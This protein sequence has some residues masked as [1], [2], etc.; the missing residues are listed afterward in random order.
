MSMED[1]THKQWQQT[2]GGTKYKEFYTN[3]KHK[4]AVAKLCLLHYLGNQFW[5]KNIGMAG[6]YLNHKEIES[7]TPQNVLGGIWR[8]LVFKKSISAAVHT[9]YTD[10][11]EKHTRPSLDA[12]GVVLTSVISE[13]SK[14]YI[15]IDALDE[16]PE[17]QWDIILK[18]LT[19]LGPGV[20]LM[21]TSHSHIPL[22]L[23]LLAKLHID[24]LSTENT[25]KDVEE[26][27][28]QL[29]QDL[30]QTYHDAMHRI[31]QQN[32]EDQEL[33]LL[34]LLWVAHAKWPLSVGEVQ[35][36]L[37]IEPETTILYPDKVPDIEIIVSACVGLIVVDDTA[38]V[39]RLIHY[40]TQDYLDTFQ[41]DRF[42]DAH[43]KIVSRSL[44]YLSFT[45]FLELP[46]DDM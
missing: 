26:A 31:D 18:Y 13:Y 36:A 23:F 46:K 11:C 5:D 21:L 45:N 15:V 29:P 2:E 33:A 6:A 8:Q 27:V 37:T 16:Y 38:S 10:H 7:Q 43:T 44:T 32:Q 28:H 20:N 22:N 41:K 39:V 9:L 3:Y 25:V 35:E 42:P 30:K 14:V 1:I 19:V 34:A 17:Q 12:L 40:T 24:S 4:L